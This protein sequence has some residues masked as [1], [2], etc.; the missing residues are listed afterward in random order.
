M[1]NQ[2]TRPVRPL[3][4]SSGR[5]RSL[6]L[7]GATIKIKVTGIETGGA[8]SLIEY[9]APPH[10]DGPRLHWHEHTHQGFYMLDG[11]LAFIVGEETITATNG[12][13][14]YVPAGIVHTFFNPTAA[15]ATFLSWYSPGG[16]E[17][18]FEELSD[19]IA[20]E[21]I[22]P[23]ADR[24]RLAAILQRYDQHHVAESEQA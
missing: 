16:P 1:L 19:L 14:I 5:E 24:S 10:F 3:V 2:I 18:M 17:L 7:L 21:P 8:W 9:T 6:S 15:P 20:S 23:P 11:L 22:W 4:R 13:S 12:C